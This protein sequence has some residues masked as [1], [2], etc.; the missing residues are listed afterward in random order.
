[1]Y[2]PGFA[3]LRSSPSL[4]FLAA[5]GGLAALGLLQQTYNPT[6]AFA[7][8]AQ[9]PSLAPATAEVCDLLCTTLYQVDTAS[10]RDPHPPV[11]SSTI[12][13]SIEILGA[14][15]AKNCS[16]AS[17][18][19][20]D[21]TAVYRRSKQRHGLPKEIIL[22]QYEVCP[23]CNKVRAF[24]DYHKVTLQLPALLAG[25]LL[26]VLPMEAT[27]SFPTCRFHTEPWRSTL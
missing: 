15:I 13:A 3:P 9:P 11:H 26:H 25:T 21:E 8:P 12:C 20:V 14:Q 23:F 19:Q 1:M 6:V 24:L 17:A 7:E 16:S 5:A 18:L 10:Q 4:G 22:Y 2:A 27:P